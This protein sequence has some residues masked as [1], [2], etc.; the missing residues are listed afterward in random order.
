MRPIL[1]IACLIA[2]SA[3]A[4]WTIDLHDADPHQTAL[5]FAEALHANVIA[6]GNAPRVTITGTAPDAEWAF[7]QLA[8]AAGWE[9]TRVGNVFVLG[10]ADFVARVARRHVLAGG[11]RRIDILFDRAETGATLNLL[12]DVLGDRAPHEASGQVTI[13]AR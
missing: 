4:D 11:G 12:G 3:R 7:A 9:I 10:P 8:N 6:A 2:S 1:V 13:R 5:F